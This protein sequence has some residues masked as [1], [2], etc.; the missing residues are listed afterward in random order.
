M[1][2]SPAPAPLELT[3]AD[4]VDRMVQADSERLAVFSGYTAMRRYN[5]DNKKLNKHAEMTVRVACNSTGA[6]T[7]EV[8]TESG[9]GFVRSRIIGRMIDAEREASEKGEQQQTRIIPKNYN[10]RLLRT[11]MLEGRPQYVLEISPKTR[12][13]YM[14]R[15]HIWVDAQDFAITRIEGSPAKNPSFW[16]RSV[17][18]VHRYERI[19]KFWL[20]VSNQ[21]HAEARIF[22]LTEV[23]IDYFDY[24]I[25]DA[26]TKTSPDLN[27]G[28]GAVT[29]H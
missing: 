9:S 5:F 7:F 15:G 6:K 24:F 23:S 19:G 20:P 28:V 10:F 2:G 17:G 22:G 11:D 21:S 13:P 14:V 18:V 27:I 8:V 3:V 29:A 25:T 16:I 26:H 12:N 4:I 1:E